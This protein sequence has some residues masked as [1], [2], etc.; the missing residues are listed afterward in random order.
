MS[1]QITE[2]VIPTS[3]TDLR[4][5]TTHLEFFSE[6][7]Q[8]AQIKRIREIHE[9]A[10]CQYHNPGKDM[11]GPPFELVKR[12]EKT[13]ICG[14]FNISPDSTSYRKM[15]ASFLEK[16]MDRVDAW[17][18][19]QKGT[20]PPQHAVFLIINSGKKGPIAEIIFS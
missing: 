7:Q 19:K 5:M 13:V 10:S 12:A 8:L 1:R 17:R 18:T 6:K 14:D 4:V 16:N 9:E 2:L 20:S 11:P 15:T 3:T